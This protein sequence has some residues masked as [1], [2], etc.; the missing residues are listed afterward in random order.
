MSD[1]CL[2]QDL[3]ATH[4]SIHPTNTSVKRLGGVKPGRIQPLLV[5]M[6]SSGEASTLL[7]YARLLRQSSDPDVKDHV[8]L[9][10]HMTKAQAAHAFNMRVQRRKAAAESGSKPPLQEQS[11]SN[12][13]SGSGSNPGSNPG[14][15][16]DDMDSDCL[17]LSSQ[18][19]N[20]S[21][22]VSNSQ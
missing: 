15:S 6:N 1:D 22:A 3:C 7:S 21:Q 19:G 10:K 13:G 20:N 14:S 17:D 4:L 9:N 18:R 8:Y 5:Q 11:Q 12:S 16:S 2:F